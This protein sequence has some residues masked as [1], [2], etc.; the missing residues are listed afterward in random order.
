[1]GIFLKGEQKY[2]EMVQI[3]EHLHQYVPTVSTRETIVDS[4]SGGTDEVFLD[5]FDPLALGIFANMNTFEV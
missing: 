1:M 5:E 2:E 4:H 3:V